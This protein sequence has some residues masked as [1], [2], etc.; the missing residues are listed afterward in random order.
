MKMFVLSWNRPKLVSCGLGGAWFRV[1]FAWIPSSEMSVFK[2]LL[3][4][5]AA[6]SLSSPF[7]FDTPGH[8]GRSRRAI[9]EGRGSDRSSQRQS[10]T[11]FRFTEEIVDI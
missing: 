10:S 1:G 2:G 6:V 4:P 8:E 5:W 7:P 9:A 3:R 11:F